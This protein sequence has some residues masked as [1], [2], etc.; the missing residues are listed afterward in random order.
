MMKLNNL[1]KAALLCALLLTAATSCDV[2]E[3]EPPTA[4]TEADAFSTPDRIAKSAIGMYNGLQ[5]LEFLGGRALIYGDVRS[6]DTD[7]SPYFNTIANFNPQANDATVTLAW[8]GG[9]QTLYGVNFFLRELAKN[10]SNTTPELAA[11]YTG[12]GKFIRALTNFQLVNLFAQP[13]NFTADA[14]HPG[15]PIQLVAPDA[16]EAFEPSQQLSRSTVAQVYGQIEKDLTEAIQALPESYPAGDTFSNTARATKDAARG[17]L[18]RVYLYKG[19]YARAATLAGEVITGGRHALLASPDGPFNTVSGAGKNENRE[20]IFSVAH[21]SSDNPNTNNALGQHYS[22]TKRGDITVT[23]YARIDTNLFPTRDKRRLL[24][25]SAQTFPVAATARIFTKK[26][27]DAPFDYA[28][29][30]R[31]AE[32]YLTRAEA[33]ARTT[34]VTAEAVDLLNAVRNRS[35]PNYKAAYTTGSFADATALINAILLERR[36]ELAF[37]GHR[38]YDLLRTKQNPGRINYGDDKSI[39]PIPLVDIQQNPNLAQNKG[40]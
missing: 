38:Y 34:G 22:E 19:D 1:G 10:T 2:I 39:L 21:N 12:E 35:K 6:D 9:Y 25:L 33:L 23:P 31:S 13:Y 5:N 26:Y 24:L 3:Q 20:S 37:E 7:P 27:E 14:S 11:Q 40:Y 15:I 32:M 8:T 18:S 4:F 36:L 28:P 17:L 29:I 16:A 30:V